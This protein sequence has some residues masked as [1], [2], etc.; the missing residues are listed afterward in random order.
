MPGERRLAEYR[1]LWSR[2]WGDWQSRRPLRPTGPL[3][4]SEVWGLLFEH[5][6]SPGR[7]YHT[8]DHAVGMVRQVRELRG[9]VQLGTTP[10]PDLRTVDFDVLEMAVWFHDAVYEVGAD[11]NERRSA[12]LA[13]G[14]ARAMGFSEPQIDQIREL[15]LQS[16]HRDPATTFAAR[17]LC[18]MD[19]ILLGLPWEQFVAGMELIRRECAPMPRAAEQFEKAVMLRTLLERPSIYQTGM[20]RERF[21]ERARANIRRF[22][23]P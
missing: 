7:F 8:L 14:A 13:A 10:E 15:I 6:L 11:D 9:S 16:S 23:G 2:F 5:Y 4:E 12:D 22:I 20:F 1:S 19:L 18:D 17:L 3:L 21:E